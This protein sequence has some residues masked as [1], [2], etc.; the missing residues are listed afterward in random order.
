MLKYGQRKGKTP[1]QVDRPHFLDEDVFK[2]VKGCFQARLDDDDDELVIEP[3]T[4]CRAKLPF[5][6]GY[7]E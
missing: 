6:C 3:N 2:N 1:F 5:V 4:D 7:G